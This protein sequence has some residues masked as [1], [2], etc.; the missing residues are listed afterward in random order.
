MPIQPA[1]AHLR[2]VPTVAVLLVLA[3][4]GTP[5]RRSADEA[6]S[7]SSS[8][9]RA[10]KTVMTDS[11]Q[12]ASDTAPLTP[13]EFA[14]FQKTVLFGPDDVAAL[15]ASRAIL[16]PQV[17][18][19]L[20]TWYGFVGSQPHLLASFSTKQGEP[21]PA[22]L[23]AVRERFATWIL[24]TADADYDAE[25]LALQHEIGLRHHRT[26][27]NR[28]D[29]ADAQDHIAFRHLVGLT[30]PITH[31]LRPFLESS[32]LPREEIDRMH[33]AWTK[34]VLLTVILWSRPYVHAADY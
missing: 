28:T 25:W 33:A 23:A 6:A 24:A 29:G 9:Q 16:E 17:D 3:A 7:S 10:P 5:S 30:F 4:C 27:K 21:L 31:T 1:P 18:A 26:K 8:H 20:D 11:R 2:R 14:E 19:I 34:S 22:Y 12:T 32:D 13:E 15:R